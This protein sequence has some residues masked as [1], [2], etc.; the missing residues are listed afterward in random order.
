MTQGTIAIGPEAGIDQER[1]GAP[2][3]IDAH[4]SAATRG[5]G[6]LRRRPPSEVAD[7]VRP[8]IVSPPASSEP[9]RN[10]LALALVQ[11]SSISQPVR[12]IGTV[13]ETSML[14]RAQNIGMRKHRHRGQRTYCIVLLSVGASR[15]HPRLTCMRDARSRR[16]RSSPERALS[17]GWLAGYVTRRGR[18]NEVGR[19]APSSCSAAALGGT[20]GCVLCVAARFP[21]CD[22]VVSAVSATH[23]GVLALLGQ[24]P[25]CAGTGARSSSRCVNAMEVRGCHLALYYAGG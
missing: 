12:R 14:L 25:M 8:A 5:E 23:R 3:S 20:C 17:V 21:E 15:R 24:P 11:S 22:A 13:G 2:T 10:R 1:R 18:E 16:A 19:S 6:P 4:A 9:T 7:R